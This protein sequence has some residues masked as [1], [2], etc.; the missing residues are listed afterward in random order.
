MLEGKRSTRLSSRVGALESR[1]TSQSGEQI[2]LGRRGLHRRRSGLHLELRRRLLLRRLALVRL[3]LLLLLH[4]RL[5]DAVLAAER[6]ESVCLLRRSEGLLLLRLRH[7]VLL[8]LRRQHLL[9]EHHLLLELELL[10]LLLVE[11]L[12]L[13][14]EMLL[15]LLHLLLRLEC[16]LCVHRHVLR[17]LR[18]L[19]ADHVRRRGVLCIQQSRSNMH[20]RPRNEVSVRN[21]AV[22]K[23]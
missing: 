20:R 17:L 3:A 11:L 16:R 1:Q 5:V 2:G 18:L 22:N 8:L 7:G 6:I 9:L 13:R 15:L 19:R 12:R 23:K 4:L 14:L 10:L 21:G